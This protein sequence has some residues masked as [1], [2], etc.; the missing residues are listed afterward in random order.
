MQRLIMILSVC[1]LMI[2]PQAMQAQEQEFVCPEG[3]A[4]VTIAAG[5]V[6][7]ELQLTRDGA[8][9]YMELCP[10]ITVNVLEMPDL[11]DDRLNLYFQFLEARSSELDI[12]QIDVIWPALVADYMIDLYDYASPELLE[13]Y[14]PAIVENNTVDDRL[15][16][17]P[18]YTDAGLLYYR[19]DLLEKYELQPPTT[20]DE[21][22]NAAEI[23]QAG[24]RNAGNEDFWG[25]IWQGNAYEGLTCDAL[26]WQVSHGGGVIVNAEG[27]IEVNNPGFIA[28]L[29][30]ARGW[31]GTISPEDVLYFA[32]EDGIDV[33]KAGNAAF[34]RNWPNAYIISNQDDSAVKDLFDV[35]P[36]PGTDDGPSA[37][38]LGG[39]QLAVSRYSSNPDVAASV[40]LFLTAEAEQKIRAIEGAYNPT[41]MSL[42]EDEEVLEAVPFFGS[43][44]DVF[45]GA[46]ARP[47]T[48][49]RDRYNGVSEL[50]YLAVYSVLTGEADA[51]EAMSNLETDINDLLKFGF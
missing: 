10:N 8:A 44:L 48:V 11:T 12:Y 32:E 19:S 18:W 26:E 15:I 39:W 3:E 43:L 29:E 33:F 50:Y 34:M 27:E 25:Y 9:R 40:T 30:R 1:W 16:A 13:S 31:I 23:I 46:V 37:A 14:F 6:G 45:T 42:Y 36:L 20:W 28:A 41:I 4:A 49:T 38:T 17:M 24:E 21:L 35:S 2:V 7:I 51:T 5:A 22:E 47:S